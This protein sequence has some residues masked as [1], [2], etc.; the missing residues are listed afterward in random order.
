M[1]PV[2]TDIGMLCDDLAAETTAL[3]LLLADL[4]ESGWATAT[5]AEGWDVRDQI[6]HLAYFD[7]RAR[8]A[9]TDA[10]AFVEHRDDVLSHPDFADRIAAD[11]R[12]FDGPATLDWFRQARR[13]LVAA[14]RDTDPSLRVPWYGPDMSAASSITARIM[15]TWAHGQDVTDGLGVQ[16]APTDR[17]RHVAFIGARA[18]ANSYQARGLE[19]PQASVR[20]EV[21]APSGELWAFGPVDASD[22]VRGPALDFC[23]AVTQRRHLDDL[24]L[25]IEGPV[26]TEWMSIAQA[27]AGPPGAGRKPG[28]FDRSG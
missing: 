1:A 28:Q 11:S 4:D 2:A 21:V 7:D 6:G 5:P 8:E 15:E 23:L 27:F 20:V 19:A 14:A 26:A 25:H 10:D 18:F 12:R 13:A 3:E 22:V 17:L 9:M 16:R 24:E